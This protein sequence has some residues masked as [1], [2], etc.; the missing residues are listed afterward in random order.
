M[1]QKYG[2]NMTY[3]AGNDTYHIP[4]VNEAGTYYSCIWDAGGTDTM[5]GSKTLA[6]EGD[7]LLDAGGSRALVG[8][9]IVC[10]LAITPN[11]AC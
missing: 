3:H 6:Q 9:P 8:S 2:A 10:E 11:C 1:Q 4:D 5:V 7:C